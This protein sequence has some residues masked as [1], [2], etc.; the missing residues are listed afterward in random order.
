MKGFLHLLRVELAE[1][2]HDF[3][4]P[5]FLFGAALAYLLVF[6]M[7]YI[8]NIVTAVPTVILDEDNSAL[9]RQLVRDFEA[10]DSYQVTAY[11]TSQEEMLAALHDQTAIAA[12]DIPH[13]FAKKARNGS[14]STVLYLTNGA[15]IILTNITSAAAQSITED[16]SNKL[17]AQQVALRYG[18]NEGLVAH[19]I[20]PVT[21]HLRVLYNATQGY[22]F[23]FLIGLA[24]VAFQ[25]GIVFA[26][27]ASSLYEVEHP[28]AMQGYGIAEIMLAKTTVYWSLAM[29]S[30]LLV[31]LGITQGLCI[32]LHA[33]LWQLLLLAGIFILAAIGFCF[34]FSSFFP[35]ELPFVRAAILYPVPC[36]IFSG[37]TWPIES[38]GPN[39]QTVAQFFP[40]THFSNTVRELFLIGSSPSYTMCLEKLG[41]LILLFFLIGGFLYRRNLSK[42]REALAASHATRPL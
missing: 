39:M 21:V 14:Y 6:G 2:R 25:Q 28:E 32:D 31:L 20:A 42:R 7:L 24:M 34:F 18:L 9:S 15:N 16:F 40:L 22:M 36:F 30:Y 13:D 29:C 3:R 11:V 23:F 5:A 17:A 8:P 35:A 12:I 19:Y 1:I 26:V 41:G 4:R 10:S 38:M 37:Y 33:P 27:G